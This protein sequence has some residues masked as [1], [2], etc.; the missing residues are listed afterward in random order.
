MSN[1]I[2]D[3]ARLLRLPGLGGLSIAPVFGAITTGITDINHLIILFII[4]AFASIYGFVLNDYIDVNVD[5]LSKE[6]HNRP[7]VKGTI[8]KKNALIIC[9]LCFIGALITIHVNYYSDHPSYYTALGIILLSALLGTFYNLYGKK[10]IA[11]DFI[12]ALSEA[13]LVLFGA[14]ILQPYGGDITIFT[15]LIFIL[16]F[17]QLLYENAVSGGIKDADHDPLM[18]VKNIALTSGVKVSPDKKLFIPKKFLLFGLS[19]RTFSILL[20]FYPLLIHNAQ[21]RYHPINILIMLIL[22]LALYYLSFKLLTLKYFDRSSIRKLITGQ[23]FIRYSLVPLMMIPILPSP[24]T[25]VALILL[26][27]I[28]YIVFTPLI[29]EKLFK[30]GL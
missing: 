13:L 30:P 7:L 19:I 6:L 17:N 4:G 12:I 8:P 2:S 28:W 21:Y 16:T 27:F 22:T 18:N 11:S 20:I 15:W 25:A 9:I 26:P 3:Y 14:I 24:I 5:K 23:T 10:Y 1:I 29:G